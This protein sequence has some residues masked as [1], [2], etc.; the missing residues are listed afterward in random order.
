MRNALHKRHKLRDEKQFSLNV[1]ATWKTCNES[2]LKAFN[3]FMQNMHSFFR[4]SRSGTIMLRR[5]I[6]YAKC[7]HKA[8]QNE[9]LFGI[10][11]AV[12]QTFNAS[13]S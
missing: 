11:F 12:I 9:T 7:G 2:I 8:K 1:H 13:P 6:K 4:S 5:K 10:F 3:V